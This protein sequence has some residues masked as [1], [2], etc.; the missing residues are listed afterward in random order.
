LNSQPSDRGVGGPTKLLRWEGGGNANEARALDLDQF[1]WW[2][3]GQGGGEAGDGVERGEGH[4]YGMVEWF[5]YRYHVC[6]W[7]EC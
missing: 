7:R 6:E 4:I 5:I 2:G 3:D 1:C